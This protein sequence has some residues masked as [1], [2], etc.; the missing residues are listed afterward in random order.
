MSK[1]LFPP[2]TRVEHVRSIVDGSVI[3]IF[4]EPPD[5][6]GNVKVTSALCTEEASKTVYQQ[7]SDQGIKENDDV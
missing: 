6:E 1:M 5:A 7:L 3:F 2:G 4:T